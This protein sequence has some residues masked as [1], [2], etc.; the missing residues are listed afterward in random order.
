ML[1]EYNK[2][3][4]VKAFVLSEVKYSKPE[5]R[6]KIPYPYSFCTVIETHVHSCGGSFHASDIIVSIMLYLDNAVNEYVYNTLSLEIKV[7]IIITVCHH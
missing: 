1:D 2:R 7:L 3:I 4:A 6:D 5:I